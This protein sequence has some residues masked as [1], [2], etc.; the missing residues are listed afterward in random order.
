MT[1]ASRADYF[2]AGTGAP[3]TAAR[4]VDLNAIERFELV[5]GILAR[6]AVGEQCMVNFVEFERGGEAPMHSHAEEQLVLVIEGEVRMELD[7]N[8]RVLRVGEVAVIPSWSPHSAIGESER[9]VT[10][11]IFSPPRAALL[12]LMNDAGRGLTSSDA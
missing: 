12:G 5:P 7:G 9:A 3:T 1:S 4:V 11:E 6:A 2:A 8:A 10:V